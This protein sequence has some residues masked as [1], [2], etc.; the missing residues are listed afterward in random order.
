[1]SSLR[2]ARAALRARPAAI[3]RPIQRRGYAEVANDKIKLSLALPHQSIYK[4]QDVVQVNL[5][6]ETGDMG[7]LANHVAS[8]EQ[9]K[10]GLVEIIEES[11]G[12]K[13]FFLS[14]GFAVVQPN[15]VLSI[16]AVEGY[17][18]EDFSAEAVRNQI[19]EAQKI[20]SGSGS[21]A[22]IAEAKIELEVLE[23]LQ[24]ALKYHTNTSPNKHT[25]AQVLDRIGRSYPEPRAAGSVGRTPSPVG[26]HT[27]ERSLTS[28]AIEP[29]RR[30]SI[31]GPASHL[32]GQTWQSQAVP[33]PSRQPK[34]VS[35]RSA[36]NFF[37]KKVSQPPS[38]SLLPS[39]AT[40]TRTD[41]ASP[42]I[43]SSSPSHS[44]TRDPS[45]DVLRTTRPLP[46]EKETSHTADEN[47]FS[48]EKDTLDNVDKTTSSTVEDDTSPIGLPLRSLTEPDAV[49]AV[50][51]VTPYSDIEIGESVP[52]VIIR[53]ATVV[54]D[55]VSQEDNPSEP[56]ADEDATEHMKPT[57]V[58]SDPTGNANLLGFEK[59]VADGR[60]APH[61]VSRLT[62]GVDKEPKRQHGEGP[63][64][65]LVR[66][67]STRRSMS[68]IETTQAQTPNRRQSLLGSQRARSYR[69]IRTAF[70]EHGESVPKRTE[71]R[72]THIPESLGNP[73]E[74]ADGPTRRRFSKTSSP[75]FQLFR[76]RFGKHVDIRKRPEVNISKGLGYDGS[77]SPNLSRRNTTS[78]PVPVV[79]T[80]I[81][82]LQQN[83]E[84]PGDVDNRQGYG[85]RM[86]QDFGFPGART[87]PH[88]RCGDTFAEDLGQIIESILKDHASTL[89]DVIDNIKNSQPSLAKLQRAS[90]ELVQRCQPA[91]CCVYSGNTCQLPC[92]HQT[93]DEASD[94]VSEPCSDQQQISLYD[95]P[96]EAKKLNVGSPGRVGPNIND[97]RLNLIKGVQSMP[98][99]V[100][101][102]K[103]AADDFGVDLEL[104]PGAQDEEMFLNATY[105][106]TPCY[107]CSSCGDDHLGTIGEIIVK[108]EEDSW[109]QQARRRL[110][111]ILETREQ[112]MSE[113]DSIA[114][115]IGVQVEDH[116]HPKLVAD[117]AQSVLSEL[118]T[119][120]STEHAQSRKKPVDAATK[121]AS[122]II[123]KN[124]DEENSG[125]ARSELST[126]VDSATTDSN[127]L[128]AL[129]I[130]LGIQRGERSNY[131]Q[132]S[133]STSE[134]RCDLQNKENDVSLNKPQL[135][136]AVK[137]IE[138]HSAGPSYHRY[139]EM[140]EHL[141]NMIRD[142]ERRLDQE[143]RKISTLGYGKETLTMSAEH[144]ADSKSVGASY[145]MAKRKAECPRDKY[146]KS[147][148]T[149]YPAR[150]S[151]GPRS[152]TTKDETTSASTSDNEK[153]M[154]GAGV[155][156][157]LLEESSA[158]ER[159]M[160]HRR[161][162]FISRQPMRDPERTFSFS[163]PTSCSS[164][165]PTV[166]LQPSPVTEPEQP[167]H[168]PTDQKTFS[169]SSPLQPV[170]S[171][172]ASSPST[173]PESDHLHQNSTRG[174]DSIRCRQPN[175]KEPERINTSFLHHSA[176]YEPP[177]E[178]FLLEAKDQM[179]SRLNSASNKPEMELYEPPG[180]A[181]Y[182][183]SK[184]TDMKGPECYEVLPKSVESSP[185]GEKTSPTRLLIERIGRLLGFPKI[186]YSTG[187]GK[188]SSASSESFR[189][190]DI[191]EEYPAVYSAA[192]KQVRR[193]DDATGVHTNLE[194]PTMTQLERSPAAP[195]E[196]LKCT[197]GSS[198]TI[199]DIQ[200]TANRHHIL[201]EE[202]ITE[203]N[204]KRTS[205]TGLSCDSESSGFRSSQRNAEELSIACPK[206]ETSE[207]KAPSEFLQN[208]P[209]VPNRPQNRR[210]KVAAPGIVASSPE[211]TWM[212]LILATPPSIP[213]K[214]SKKLA[215]YPL[216]Q[217]HPPVS[218]YPL[219]PT[220]VWIKPDNMAPPPKLKSLSPIRKRRCRNIA[221]VHLL[222]AVKTG[223]LP[224]PFEKRHQKEHQ[225]HLGERYKDERIISANLNT[226]IMTED[227]V[228]SP[229]QQKNNS[230]GNSSF[231]LS[232]TCT[233][234]HSTQPSK[235]AATTLL[236]PS[237]H[238]FAGASTSVHG[239]S[240]QFA[241]TR[242]RQQKATTRR[243]VLHRFGRYVHKEELELDP[244][245]P[246]VT[247]LA[248]RPF[249]AIRRSPVSINLR[250]ERLLVTRRRAI[251]APKRLHLNVGRRVTRNPLAHAELRRMRN[252]TGLCPKK[253]HQSPKSHTYQDA[254]KQ[255]EEVKYVKPLARLFQKC[256]IRAHKQ[257][258][259][260][261]QITVMPS[262]S[263]QKAE[264]GTLPALHS[265]PQAKRHPPTQTKGSSPL[266]RLHTRLPII[267]VTPESTKCQGQ[268]H[269]PIIIT[270]L[271]RDRLN[272]QQH[273]IRRPRYPEPQRVQA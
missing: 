136:V 238:L 81:D 243:P 105:E 72:S 191:V 24:A 93:A 135:N 103:S 11:G 36:K 74:V 185:F 19:G 173:L 217:Q 2:I 188:C 145:P 85:R 116:Q 152:S 222:S 254:G 267:K 134:L 125:V 260:H 257:R 40:A 148:T 195:T 44:S 258:F 10:P 99:L 88:D 95:A 52:E 210:K 269:I 126:V 230:Q 182:K 225:C 69:D 179:P 37:E 166:N 61:S 111:E 54:A 64:D 121:R 129:D 201:P 199:E 248:S 98:D 110:M 180:R 265:R 34:L 146:R 162:S 144:T 12:S 194:L 150:Q 239:H 220:P 251:Y 143:Q 128:P 256:K 78:G 119:V 18:L 229:F 244:R 196:L 252:I 17:P 172:S 50:Q 124:I 76:D 8:I 80:G 255:T 151:E 92:E 264:T 142:L 115:D 226:S 141:E 272:P 83:K 208:T 176:L 102:V 163:S 209:K 253:V 228:F 193:G 259:N 227:P 153:V 207:T 96:K 232:K 101:L 165:E 87:R 167:L 68:A 20:A 91:S 197:S 15:S 106:S 130:R 120:S 203:E 63:S 170:R 49:E 206:L 241:E 159:I 212:D 273:S 223:S 113:L 192:A 31:P 198:T 140:I 160:T 204:P 155:S 250:R 178:S 5:P 89:Q 261:R 27:E 109:L 117:S 123:N 214:K 51:S 32:K 90:G 108:D 154:S 216:D 169:E 132:H 28:S 97:R 231:I 218:S 200:Y 158:T 47:T 94:S 100:D 53:R 224:N 22:D 7:V 233:A 156:T 71:S 114:G 174:S 3:A 1:M 183:T 65:R 164:D 175:A 23:S 42:K 70:E 56:E 122:I 9:L 35:V 58:F 177:E 16:N 6:A 82:A 242:H 75:N 77:H 138:H 187:S 247:N 38:A 104:R 171:N 147:P 262:L 202:T 13:Q 45:P 139:T 107:S 62:L 266:M 270:P 84:V 118:S 161:S 60:P 234:T 66:R 133:S 236:V 127:T 213:V 263:S 4:S 112:L 184:E 73:D 246:L 205:K 211:A 237:P 55:M 14:G 168:F 43:H 271:Q 235:G 79:N 29:K 67:L 221:C 186:R 46:T 59:R 240:P 86:T 41:S 131:I 268:D 26:A 21:E 25:H 181:Y 245:S 189:C 39:S 137:H 215:N 57:T 149:E 190:V 33:L 249:V 30:S 157:I 48:V 219:R